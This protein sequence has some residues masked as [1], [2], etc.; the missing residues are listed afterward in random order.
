MCA[1]IQPSKKPTAVENLF[2]L[3]KNGNKQDE[4]KH[5]IAI[6]YIANAFAG[7]QLTE[8]DVGND[9]SNVRMTSYGSTVEGFEWNLKS[10][11]STSFIHRHSPTTIVVQLN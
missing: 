6:Q 8:T 10:Q 11:M 7:T 4:W 3:N 1:T 5:Q 9:V 2:E